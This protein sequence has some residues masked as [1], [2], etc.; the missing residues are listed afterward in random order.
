MSYLT[1]LKAKQEYDNYWD[2]IK[3]NFFISDKDYYIFLLEKTINDLHYLI[4][5]I[6]LNHRI[7]FSKKEYK[8]YLNI[9]ETLIK[10]IRKDDTENF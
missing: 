7:E 5:V 9:L 6:K 10:N 2:K 4:E 3:N 8:M 1:S